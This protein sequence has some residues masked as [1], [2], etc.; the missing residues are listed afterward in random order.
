MWPKKER[1]TVL[2]R[3]Q[4]RDKERNKGRYVGIM[5]R[6]TVSESE[7]QTRAFSQIMIQI[8]H[9]F[10]P[11]PAPPGHREVMQQAASSSRREM[12]DT[13]LNGL[14]PPLPATTE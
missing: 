4:I 12:Q 2:V 8:E 5:K 1:E 10:G 3:E 13:L 14:V 11:Y 9:R 7:Y 6:K